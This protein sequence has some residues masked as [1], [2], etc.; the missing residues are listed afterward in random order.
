MKKSILYLLLF[1]LSAP[2]FASQDTLSFSPEITFHNGI[3]FFGSG[4]SVRKEIKNSGFGE[5]G[6]PDSF[7]SL[8]LKKSPR[9]EEASAQLAIKVPVMSKYVVKGLYNY[10]DTNVRGSAYPFEP[11]SMNTSVNTIA[12]LGYI[13]LKLKQFRAGAGPAFHLGKANVAYA[14]AEQTKRSFSKPGFVLESGFS[15]PANKRFYVDLQ[16]QYFYVGKEDMGK[17]TFSGTTVEG[18]TVSKSIDFRETSFNSFS[19]SLGAGFRFRK[20]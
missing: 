18:N 7:F 5:S 16:L 12:A 6:G 15:S 20:G 17:Y 8:G 2:A 9:R 19:F 14:E 13:P 3:V 4:H 10:R 11:L 1:V